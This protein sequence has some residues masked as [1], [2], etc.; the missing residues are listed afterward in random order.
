MTEFY[1]AF[2]L[3]LTPL[4]DEYFGDNQCELRCN[5]SAIRVD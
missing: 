1:P 4:A 3:E 2:S 5:K